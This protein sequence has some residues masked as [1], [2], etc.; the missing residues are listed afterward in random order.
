MNS[1]CQRTTVFDFS[2]TRIDGQPCELAEYRG[3]VL[4]IVNVA[5]HCVFTAQ[6]APLEN[7]YQKYR[8]RDFQ[9]LGFPCGQFLQQELKTNEEIQQFCST[10][11][12][13]SFPMFSKIDV[14]GARTH[15]LYK[16]L[17]AAAPGW[18]GSRRIAWNFTKFLVDR[19]GTKVLRRASATPPEKIARDINRLL[20]DRTSRL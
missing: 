11:Y 9:I 7:L 15:P 13:V 2:A 20:S 18:F 12:N 10:T 1:A 19:S 17:K 8:S 14:N 3:Q 5:S 6:Y 16:Y 4:L